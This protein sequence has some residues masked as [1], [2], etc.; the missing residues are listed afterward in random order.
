[1]SGR[2]GFGSVS[3]QFTFLPAVIND[4]TEDTFP[5]LQ[6]SGLSCWLKMICSS[7]RYAAV[8]CSHQLFQ[9]AA[10]ITETVMSVLVQV[11]EETF[12]S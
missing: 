1:M 7:Q 4:V 6:F 5:T 12:F 2:F 11:M 9:C 3:L 10:N 8:Q